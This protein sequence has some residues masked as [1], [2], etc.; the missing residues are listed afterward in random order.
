MI[1]TLDSI[2]QGDWLRGED[3]DGSI[4][5]VADGV[6]KDLPIFTFSESVDR[7]L[8]GLALGSIFLR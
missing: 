5:G 7:W 1:E 6:Y 2:W 3:E 8:R 4:C